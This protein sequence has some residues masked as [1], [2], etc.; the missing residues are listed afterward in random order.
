MK[1]LKFY[2]I[3]AFLVVINSCSEKEN[4]SKITPPTV[5]KTNPQHQ[6]LG[7]WLYNPK[8]DFERRRFEITFSED[9][10]LKLHLTYMDNDKTYEDTKNYKYQIIDKN[11]I[12]FDY[13][14]NVIGEPLVVVGEVEK[15]NLRLQC[16]HKFDRKKNGILSPPI[17]CWFNDFKK[18]E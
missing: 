8:N 3:F 2:I 16:K 17:L 15:N 10:N 12:E 9:E 5:E 6:I 1:K 13:E 14:P 7:K 11:K 18:V 4:S